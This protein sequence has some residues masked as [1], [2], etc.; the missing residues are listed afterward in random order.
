LSASPRVISASLSGN[1]NAV[2]LS[3]PGVD[4]ES[5]STRKTPAT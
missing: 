4:R 1:Y 3:D 5:R 2:I